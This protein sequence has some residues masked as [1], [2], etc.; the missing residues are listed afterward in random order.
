M[1]LFFHIALGM[2]R[3]SMPPDISYE[4]STNETATYVKGTWAKVSNLG[5]MSLEIVVIV[6]T[7]IIIKHWPFCRFPPALPETTKFLRLIPYLVI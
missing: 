1:T 4:Y 5:E 3:V 7:I 2:H 6:I